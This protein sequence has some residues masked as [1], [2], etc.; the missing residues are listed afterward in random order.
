M[1]GYFENLWTT[2]KE[3]IKISIC[4][5]TKF[6]P[7]WHSE[8]EFICAIDDGVRL[9]VADTIITLNK[10]DFAFVPADTVHSYSD[11]GKLKRFYILWASKKSLEF[12]SLARKDLT[13]NTFYFNQ[14]AEISRIFAEKCELMLRLNEQKLPGFYLSSLSCFYNILAAVEREVDW[15]VVKPGEL[16][17]ISSIDNALKYIS[18]SFCEDI[19]LD[20]VAKIVNYNSSYF[21]RC[22]KKY[23]GHGFNS[24]LNVLRIEKAESLLQ[25]SNVSISSIAKECG[26]QNVQSF[27]RCF[28]Q[29]KGCTPK[30][31]RK[32][33]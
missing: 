1:K 10:G 3:P 19:T 28:K 22:F 2:E 23:T 27:I 24:F 6:A 16:N 7:H 31:I 18:E 21:S 4:V 33:F 30:E 26:Y 5:I 13:P 32:T 25:K 8:S 15:L 29:L 9:N 20:S 14:K 12:S 11:M 17:I